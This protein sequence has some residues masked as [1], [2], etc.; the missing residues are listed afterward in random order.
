MCNVYG[1][2]AN[3]SVTNRFD[4]LRSVEFAMGY[5]FVLRRDFRPTSRF[6]VSH[7]KSSSRINS[8]EIPIK[9]DLW[10]LSMS[11]LHPALNIIFLVFETHNS[12]VVND[13]DVQLRINPDFIANTKHSLNSPR[14]SIRLFAHSWW[15]L[16][17][18]MSCLH[19]ILSTT[20]LHTTHQ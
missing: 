10:N 17:G 8:F 15:L 19:L 14:P 2:F 12:L 13:H 20:F 5:L 16:L 18:A 6:L 11:S 3:R 4:A 7:A 1:C 9:I